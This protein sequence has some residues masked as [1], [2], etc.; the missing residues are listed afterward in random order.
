MII[1]KF[2]Q[3]FIT[4]I[5]SGPHLAM[6]RMQN[7]QLQNATKSCDL[8]NGK[9][10]IKIL[11]TE[12]MINRVEGCH[13]NVICVC[14]CVCVSDCNIGACIHSYVHTAE[15]PICEAILLLV[16]FQIINTN[17]GHIAL[18]ITFQNGYITKWKIKLTS[19][20]TRYK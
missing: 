9:H 19:M 18:H 2:L 14:V 17:L 1:H 3:V 8:S 6:H 13:G 10:V 16:T 11:P 15:N 5:L 20:H 4:Y 7:Q 12:R